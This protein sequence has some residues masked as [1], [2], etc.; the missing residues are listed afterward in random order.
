MNRSIFL[1]IVF[2]FV[3]MLAYANDGAFFAAGNQLIPI[4]E[5]D[6]SV[7][8]EILHI[9][10]I[11]NRYI[12]VSVYYEFFNPEAE[13]E[14]TVGF[15]ARPPEGDVDGAPRNGNHPY[16]YNFTVDVNGKILPYEVA[17]VDDSLYVQNG[18]IKEINWDT[19]EGNKAGN[20]IDFMY[21]YHFRA[22]FKKGKNIVKHTY[23]FD[24]SGGIDYNY[25]FEYVLTA[26]GRWANRQID[27]FTLIVEMEDFEVFSINHTFFKGPNEWIINGIGKAVFV[28]ENQIMESDATK[29]YMQRGNLVF[30]KKNFKPTG[31]LSLYSYNVWLENL[32]FSIYQQD[33]IPTENVDEVTKRIYRNLPFARRGNI[34]SDDTLQNFYESMDWYIPNPNYRPNVEMLWKEEQT[35]IKR[36]N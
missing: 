27:D 30:Q 4:T 25:Y 10:K 28:P 5:N 15:E 6:I 2:A 20:Y 34:F 24:V 36:W 12:E 29:F 22:T 16:M 3:G 13:K 21:V 1:S 14:I 26:A 9:K 31:E 17:Y 19:F 35:W 11:N 33:R 8:K 23:Q 7:Q 18:Q 32:P